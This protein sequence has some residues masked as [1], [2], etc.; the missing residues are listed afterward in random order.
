MVIDAVEAD[1]HDWKL[2]SLDEGYYQGTVQNGGTAHMAEGSTPAE[3]LQSAWHSAQDV[4]V[5]TVDAGQIDVLLAAGEDMWDAGA[6]A[7]ASI[8]SL[9]VAYRVANERQERWRREEIAQEMHEREETVTEEDFPCE[10]WE[11]VQAEVKRRL[12]PQE[13]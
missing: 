12:Q 7:A 3:A 1:G 13:A 11:D 6:A 8:A 9:Y 4:D 5:G 2:Q 10:V